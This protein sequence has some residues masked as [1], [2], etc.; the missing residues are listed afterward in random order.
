MMTSQ[1]PRGIPIYGLLL[2]EMKK[3]SVSNN[4][5]LE[6]QQVFTKCIVKS[7]KSETFYN[8]IFPNLAH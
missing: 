4:A 7:R 3:K 6:C 1:N 2:H 8:S 5:L